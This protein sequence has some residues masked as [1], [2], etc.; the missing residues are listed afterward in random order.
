[1]TP[2]ARVAAAIDILDLI[3]GG[4]PAEK[5]LTAWARRSRFAGSGD[6]ATIRDHVFDA[7]RCRRSHAALGGAETGRGLMLG[8]LIAAGQDPAGVFTGQGHAPAPLSAAE[9]GRAATAP[10][11]LSAAMTEAEACDIPDWLWPQWQA[12]LGDRA[13]ETAKLQRSRAPVFLR[14]NL[15]RTSPAAATRALADEGIVAIPH[16]LADTALEVT[17]G[18]RRI[19]GSA[20]YREGLVELQDAASQAVTAAL[21]L[22]DGMRVLDY[23]AGGGGKTLAMAGRVRAGFTA[24]DANPARLNDLKPRAARAGVPV[25]VT[26]RPEGRFDLV[27][28]DVPCSG[29]GS[30][31]RA[32]EGKWLLD[33]DGLDHLCEVQSA[34]LDRTAPMVAE[35]GTLAYVTCSV[36][37]CENDD[38]VADFLSAHPGWRQAARHQWLPGDGGDGFFLSCL[39]RRG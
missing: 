10:D 35:G 7:L 27:L 16:P 34:I 29:S 24:H 37:N 2:E 19:A 13:A 11:T 3:L 30:W 31:R 8:A 6:R 36:L 18:A 21:P 22:A 20:A 38:R 26:A 4:E 5:A 28:C 25:T 39:K 14:V 1:M 15:R 9:A 23:C 32:P 12:S 17:E 33:R